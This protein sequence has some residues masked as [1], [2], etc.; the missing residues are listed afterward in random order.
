MERLNSTPELIREDSP[1]PST[2]ESIGS[3]SG[4]SNE[5]VVEIKPEKIKTASL[6]KHLKGLSSWSF[7]QKNKIKTAHDTAS[8]S[9]G[10]AERALGGAPLDQKT[11]EALYDTALQN[12]ERFKIVADFLANPKANRTNTVIALGN[13]LQEAKDT[14]TVALLN[15]LIKNVSSARNKAATEIQSLMRGHQVRKETVFPSDIKKFLDRNLKGLTTTSEEPID[16]DTLSKAMAR[17]ILE[18]STS[19]ALSEHGVLLNTGKSYLFP[20]GE[21]LKGGST[22]TQLPVELWVKKTPEG[23][24]IEMVGQKLGSGTYKTVFASRTFDMALSTEAHE[25][26]P[27]KETAVV[28]ANNPSANIDLLM[29]TELIQKEF[30]NE[31]KQ[32][33]FRVA[34]L[35]SHAGKLKKIQGKN[36]TVIGARSKEVFNYETQQFE[37]VT[38]ARDIQ[39]DGDLN[40]ITDPKTLLQTFSDAAETLLK[41]HAKGI[42]HRDIKPPNILSKEGRGFLGDFDLTA[43][44]GYNESISPT[45]YQYWDPLS[46]NCYVTP[47]SDAHGLARS[48]CEKLFGAAYENSE[49]EI[50]NLRRFRNPPPELKAIRDGIAAIFDANKLTLNFLNQNPKIEAQLAHKDPKEIQKA[51]DALQKQFP[52]YNNFIKLVSKTRPQ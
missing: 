39:Y 28:Q 22:Q 49:D 36:D 51:V 26:S 42:I 44:Q 52:A 25:K 11:Q 1:K 46:Q 15:S 41:F 2:P 18:L 12:P 17:E 4:Y 9:I 6:E 16:H 34:G 47:L 27:L 50:R 21:N 30:A 33:T 13:S 38:V 40:K 14:E 7:L 5:D 19:G 48:M 29:G 32:D 10:K 3:G 20:S 45:K 43:K 8:K 31:L 35:V 24:E 23:V 37:S